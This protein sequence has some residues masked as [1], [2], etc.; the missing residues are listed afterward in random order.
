MDKVT[1]FHVM[2]R[3]VEVRTIGGP[4]GGSFGSKVMSW[5]VQCYA[6]LLSRATGKPVKLVFSKEEHM[7]AFTLRPASRMKARVG[8]KKDGTV[9]AISGTWLI[10]TGYYS[11][12]TQAQVA[13]GC[14]EV[15]IMVRC[16]NWESQACDCLY[17]PERLRHRKGFRRPGA[18]VYP[19]T[20][21]EFSH[22]ETGH[23]PLS[24]SQKKFRQAR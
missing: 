4:C 5:Q 2:E 6:A 20:T 21:F 11:M 19:D 18:E 1:L 3:K 23:R 17:Q 9:T 16:A 24:V 10:D 14:G 8:M 15:Q 13:V 22:G 12:T 7:A